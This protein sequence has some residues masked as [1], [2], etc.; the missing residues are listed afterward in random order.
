M[1]IAGHR[2]GA[3]DRRLPRALGA[4][5]ADAERNAFGELL[6]ALENKRARIAVIRQDAAVERRTEVLDG[7]LARRQR[8]ERSER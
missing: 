7:S 4:V 1:R 2:V 5:E 3:G 6:A 8:A